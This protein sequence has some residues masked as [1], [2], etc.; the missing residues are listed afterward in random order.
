[1]TKTKND[2]KKYVGVFTLIGKSEKIIEVSF[3]YNKQVKTQAKIDIYL[4]KNREFKSDI[5]FEKKQYN[6]VRDK[7]R[8]IKIFAKYPEVINENNLELKVISSQVD[9]IKFKPTC[10]FNIV[11]NT[12]YAV[13]ELL[14]KGLK[15]ESE[16]K[17]EVTNDIISD[18]CLVTVVDKEEENKNPFTWDIDKYDLGPNRA[19]WDTTNSN[20]LKISSKHETIRKYLG[21]ENKPFPYSESGLFRVLC[22]EILAEN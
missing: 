18:N 13:G 22:V 14:V 2:P 17:L 12:N 3:R 1:M 19:V 7:H 4:D 16:S 20:L 10:K 6:V 21:S 11:K 5:E 8:K 9:Q 15:L